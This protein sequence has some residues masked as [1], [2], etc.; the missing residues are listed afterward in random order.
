MESAPKRF[1][2]KDA[3][4]P[5]ADVRAAMNRGGD[6]DPAPGH[7]ADQARIFEV[8]AVLEALEVEDEGILA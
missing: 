5:M 3:P 1:Y 7:Y 8:L 4:D 6:F 2:T